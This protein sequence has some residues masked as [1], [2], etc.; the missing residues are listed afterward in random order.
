MAGKDLSLK[1][2]VKLL[3]KNFK[4]GINTVT[5]SI[6]SL[7]SHFMAYASAL[8]AGAIGMSN[9]ISKM[10]EVAKETTSAN[11]A[12]K[13]VSGTAAEYGSNMGWLQKIASKYGV[14]INTLTMS[15]AKFKSAAD[16]ASMSAEDQRKIFESVA[17]A[18]V[19]YG[20]SAED[21]RGVFMALQQMMSKGKVMAE[22]LRLQLAE[23]M[24]VAIQAMAKATGVSVNE[25]DKMMKQGKVLS[26]DVL[27]RFADALNEMIPNVDTN[28][29]NKSLNDLSN[30]FVELTKKLNIEGSY[31]SIVEM[32]DRLL[33]NLL[34][35]TKRW[36]LAIA[37]VFTTYLGSK[38]RGGW[39]SIMGE[40]D[41]VVKGFAK[42][43]QALD[44]ANSNEIE[45]ARAVEEAKS[46][47]SKASD[48]RKLLWAEA[49]VGE[50]IKLLEREQKAEDKF[51]KAKKQHADAQ[52]AFDQQLSKYREE[53]SQRDLAN[54]SL[55]TKAMFSMK[56]VAKQLWSTLL[57]LGKALLL[58][59]AIGGVMM[60]LGYF[61]KL[62]AEATKLRRITK[63][64]KKDLESAAPISRNA[65]LDTHLGIV[66]DQSGK[67]DDKT[68]EG[69]LKRINGLLG[70]EYKLRNLNSKK[71]DEL[72]AKAERY[73][74]YLRAQEETGR[75]NESAEK[76]RN[77]LKEDLANTYKEAVKEWRISGEETEASYVERHLQNPSLLTK[78]QKKSLAD[79]QS[80]EQLAK[81][82]AA[83]VAKHE[84]E[85]GSKGFD[86]TPPGAGA[87][88]ED[89]PI[90]KASDRYAESLNDLSAQLALGLM[91]QKEYERAKRDLIEKTRAEILASGDA[92]LMGSDFA[93]GI[94]NA[95]GTFSHGEL[96]DREEEAVD[97]IDGY[98]A[99]LEAHNRAL[100]A[101][102]MSEEEYA[103]AVAALTKKI[104]E[105]IAAMDTSGFNPALLLAL[106]NTATSALQTNQA[107]LGKLPARQRQ[108]RE[109]SP[110]AVAMMRGS[111]RAAYDLETAQEELSALREQATSAIGGMVAEIAAKESQII[112][113]KEALAIEETKEALKDLNRQIASGSWNVLESG[114]SAVDGLISSVQ[115]L[116]EVMNSDD[117]SGWEKFMAGF[118]ILSASVQGILSVIETIET[119][120]TAIKAL[121]SVKA[122][123]QA[124]EKKEAT[125][126]IGMNTAEAA[127]EAGKSA[128]KAF[129]FPWNI[130]AIG[131]A[132]AAA[133]AAFSVL[134][135]FAKGGVV[136]GNS[137][138]GDKVLARLNSGEGVLTQ[139]GMA[140]LARLAGARA[141]A[142]PA[143]IHITGRLTARGR[144]LE[145]VLDRQQRYNERIG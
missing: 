95:F 16:I 72:T 43:Q 100:R 115:N 71:L 87:P 112:S 39:R 92:G 4:S 64:V 76:V 81:E 120:S 24:P 40:Y 54:A 107:Q 70:T 41:K 82:A 145:L 7:T 133:I 49:T 69:A 62:V 58:N 117:S 14:Q 84:S 103:E 90:K 33:Q 138:Q 139:D 136:G 26:L 45:K 36:G 78:Q 11:I 135:K 93:S 19:A 141:S 52:K 130:V 129:P 17:R 34:N 118:D 38:V 97:M 125:E 137:T 37:G 127:S 94:A 50:K 110:V 128:A 122:A 143:N 73:Q 51:D 25:L 8:G 91:T 27:P 105:Q 85:F 75:Y 63:S 83:V 42:R 60:L 10:R 68:R 98:N 134:P 3:T 21:Q 44:S 74:E 96:R 142:T 6:R 65:E 46:K 109:V 86:Y 13:N 108:G 22:E 89:S 47:L 132:I 67:Y 29:L 131:G 28:N 53:K 32:V 55:W 9:F 124:M 18:S 56:A 48:D 66:R 31:K 126:T 123:E 106:G 88:D 104:Y 80:Y 59:A 1:I 144:D 57:G 102:T 114:V 140:N 79:I 101:G 61:V 111:E 23:R 113:L 30:T 12:L 121:R 119:L 35:N 2:A 5:A 77:A 20:M 15:F 99:E 116:K